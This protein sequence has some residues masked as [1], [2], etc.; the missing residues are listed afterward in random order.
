MSNQCKGIIGAIFGHNYQ[1][2]Y[3]KSA[4]ALRF[5]YKP[6]FAD[7]YEKLMQASKSLTYECDVCTRCGDVIRKVAK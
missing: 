3:S 4:P 2:R 1:G 5:P 7:E 6:N